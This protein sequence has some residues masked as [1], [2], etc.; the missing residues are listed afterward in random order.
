MELCLWLR[1][2]LQEHTAVNRV[3]KILERSLEHTLPRQ[4]I[5]NAYCLFESLSDYEGVNDT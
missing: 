2:S 3:L 4:Q 1:F 5:V